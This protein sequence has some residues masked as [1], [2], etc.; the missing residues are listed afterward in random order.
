MKPHTLKVSVWSREGFMARPGKEEGY[1]CS[2]DPDS[3]TARREAFKGNIWGGGYR[4]C[5]FLIVWQ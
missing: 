5:D 3:P 1:S 4:V 2:E